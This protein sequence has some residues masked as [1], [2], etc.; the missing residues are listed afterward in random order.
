MINQSNTQSILNCPL[1]NTPHQE[2]KN[3]IVS[4]SLMMMLLEWA[5]KQG[6]N[7]MVL[8]QALE[9][10][11]SFTD[12]VNPLKIDCFNVI[13]PEQPSCEEVEVKDCCEDDKE[14]AS[15]I[16]ACLANAGVDISNVPY[17]DV[18]PI[19]I[20]NRNNE[21]LE[22]YGASNSEIESFWDGYESVDPMAINCSEEE[23]CCQEPC[24][25]EIETDLQTEIDNIINSCIG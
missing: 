14:C 16:G 17:S 8:H 11:M 2:A 1:M 10:L 23:S 7:D 24:E 20:Q 15:E 19:I 22:G 4:S 21:D 3:I 12:G 13:V 6:D 18:A 9:N 5:S 25:P